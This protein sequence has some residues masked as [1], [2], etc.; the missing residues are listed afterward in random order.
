M[1]WNCKSHGEVICIKSVNYGGTYVP[2]EEER[3]KETKKPTGDNAL[4]AIKEDI[5]RIQDELIKQNRDNLDAMYNL[6]MDNFSASFRKTF[7]NALAQIKINADSNSA[8]AE[9]IA[10]W[11]SKLSTSIADVKAYVSDNYATTSMVSSV[12]TEL[13]NSIASVKTTATNAYSRADIAVS[14]ANDAKSSV[15]SISAKADAN[16]ASIENIVSLKGT[17]GQ[18]LYAAFKIAA[19]GDKSFIQA[20]ADKVEVTAPE[21]DLTGYVKISSLENPNQGVTVDGSNVRIIMDGSPD[22]GSN[23]VYGSELN[24]EYKRSGSS[25]NAIYASIWTKCDNNDDDESSRYAINIDTYGFRNDVG[26]Q[27]YPAIKLNAQ[28]R[29]SIASGCNNSDGAIYMSASSGYIKM[30]SMYGTRIEAVSAYGDIAYGAT[31]PGAY[32][33]IFCSD[34]IYFKNELRCLKFDSDGLYYRGER[35]AYAS[36]V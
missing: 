15:A 6:D 25:S 34:G 30:D 35:L 9:L 28:G 18:T 26:V 32:D 16:S 3:A 7:G 31:T 14:Y 2:K 23:R 4:D 10:R 11:E 13:S 36:E 17:D 29:I 12:K 21:I 33:Y 24:F 19:E 8:S 5:A 22:T 20:I 27:H 1:R